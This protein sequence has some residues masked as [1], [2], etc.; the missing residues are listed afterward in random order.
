MIDA[1]ESYTKKTI[2]FQKKILE[3]KNQMEERVVSN[4][5]SMAEK[6][7][8]QEEKIKTLEEEINEKK[9]EV[10]KAIAEKNENDISKIKKKSIEERIS[11]LKLEQEEKEAMLEKEH[12]ALEGSAE[13]Q[14]NLTTEILEVKRRAQLTE[15][16]RAIEDFNK[17]ALLIKKET[18]EKLLEIKIQQQAHENAYRSQLNS[19]ETLQKKMRESQFETFKQ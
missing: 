17:K 9:A 19:F 14:K 5:T 4:K 11:E 13:L 7:V 3:I 18:T 2:E 8:A 16:E 6:V 12:I 10:K 1:E 15:F